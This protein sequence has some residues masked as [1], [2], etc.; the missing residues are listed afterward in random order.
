MLGMLLLNDVALAQSGVISLETQASHY[1]GK[2]LNMSTTQGTI[3]VYENLNHSGSKWRIIEIEG[4]TYLQT[5]GNG[6]F[7]GYYLALK[8]DGS[9]AYMSRDPVAEARWKFVRIGNFTI[10]ENVRTGRYLTVNSNDGRV[11]STDDL[12]HSGTKWIIR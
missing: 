2:Y 5:Q 4:N 1:K 7:L 3:K 8:S 12:S 9:T 10:L 6:Q 11:W